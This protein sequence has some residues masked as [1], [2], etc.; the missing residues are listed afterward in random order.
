[1]WK[2][3]PKIKLL[4]RKKIPTTIRL[5]IFR[6][7]VLVLVLDEVEVEVEEVS[8]WV[9]KTVSEAAFKLILREANSASLYLINKIMNTVRDL[10]KTS[11]YSDR[12]IEYYESHLNVGKIKNPDAH[13]AYTGPCGDTVELF[14]KISDVITDA[15]FQTIGCVGT[16]VFG[17]ALTKMIIGKKVKDCENFNETN[18][19]KHI[20][21]VPE[22]KKH[23]AH[24][25]ALTF[26]KA[27]EQFKK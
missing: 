21:E 27:I 16:F 22:Q 14:L 13:Y 24:L 23:C 15:K 10:L 6:K 26:K 7:E 8:E 11:G 1:M 20:G 5:K 2:Q 12:A 9:D 19:L 18:L 17:S 3:I 25:V 4:N